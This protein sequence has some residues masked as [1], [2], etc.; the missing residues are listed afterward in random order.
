MLLCCNHSARCVVQK[1]SWPIPF[2][3]FECIRK[4][5]PMGIVTDKLIARASAGT[6]VG[7]GGFD[8]ACVCVGGGTN[9]QVCP[10]TNTPKFM[11]LVGF[12]PLC[13]GKLKRL[14]FLLKKKTEIQKMVG[15]TTIVLPPLPPPQWE[16]RMMPERVGRGL[17]KNGGGLKWT[18]KD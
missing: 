18:E 16:G 14:R 1:S 5:F 15:G 11:F 10:N 9:L 3:L 4:N 2:P 12:R 7:G 13:F 17:R 8:L 6:W